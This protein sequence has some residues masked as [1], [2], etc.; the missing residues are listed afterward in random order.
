MCGV[1]GFVVESCG[2][3][4]ARRQ[5]GLRR[6]GGAGG[7]RRRGR[8]EGGVEPLALS[9]STDLKSA[10]RTDEDHPDTLL[11]VSAALSAGS[12][13]QTSNRISVDADHEAISLQ[14]AIILL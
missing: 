4:Q 1:I 2:M 14:T 12:T 5:G 10:P 3:G 11:G 6:G 7:G 8:Q 9:C 13:Q